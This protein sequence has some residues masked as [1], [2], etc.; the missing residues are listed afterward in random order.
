MKKELF[1]DRLFFEKCKDDTYQRFVD[2]AFENCDFFM[3]V[4]VNYYGKGYSKELKQFEKML[5]PFQYKR[6][7]DP[8][9]PGTP[10]TYCKNTTYKVVFYPTTEETK[11]IVKSVNAL[12]EW[13][14]KTLPQDIAF[15]KGNNCWFYS[16]IHET[17]AGIVDVSEKDI[18]FCKKNGLYSPSCLNSISEQEISYYFEELI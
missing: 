8:C 15:F 11:R 9:W 14:G 16:V 7:T 5:K 18:H 3:L 6:R 1:C 10:G 2:Y 13:G 4:Y 17:M 12:E